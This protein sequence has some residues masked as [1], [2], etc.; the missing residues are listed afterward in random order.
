MEGPW[1]SGFSSS[2][3]NPNQLGEVAFVSDL[4][5]PRAPFWDVNKIRSIFTHESAEAILKMPCPR[6]V[7]DKLRWVLAPSGKFSVKEAY[8]AL[9]IERFVGHDSI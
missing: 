6:G 7:I 1:I 8:K 3:A 5:V 2:P 4:L 9:N